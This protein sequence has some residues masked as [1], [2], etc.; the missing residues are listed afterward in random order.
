MAIK[1][2][3]K[4]RLNPCSFESH[5]ISVIC[6]CTL[7]TIDY[8]SF[9]FNRSDFLFKWFLTNMF[10]SIYN[11]NNIMSMFRFRAGTRFVPTNFFISLCSQRNQ[12]LTGMAFHMNICSNWCNTSANGAK[13]LTNCTKKFCFPCKR[14][15]SNKSPCSQSREGKTVCCVL[16]RLRTVS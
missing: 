8:F 4:N 10:N 16:W 15:I 9:I 2:T 11:N 13:L 3:Y 6:V 7:N 1:K 12:M 5:E 14:R